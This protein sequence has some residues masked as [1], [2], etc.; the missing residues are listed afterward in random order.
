MSKDEFMNWAGLNSTALKI[1]QK[2]TLPTDTVPQGKGI[3]AL[4][5]KHNM[6]LDEFCKLNGITK[7]YK[8][9]KGEI[10]Y[11]KSKKAGGNAQPASATK[12]TPSKL[13]I[14]DYRPPRAFH[15]HL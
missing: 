4:A 9:A 12:Q 1:G 8:P 13:N 14:G 7:D 6:T 5:K 11:V 3:I 10:F 2:I 15:P